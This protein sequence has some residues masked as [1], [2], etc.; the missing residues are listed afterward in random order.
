MTTHV[1]IPCTHNAARSVL[2][3]GILKHWAATLGRAE[4]Q[5]ALAEIAAA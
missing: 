1:L 5:Q 2:A 3:E 4:L